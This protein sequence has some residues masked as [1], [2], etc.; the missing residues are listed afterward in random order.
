MEP[1]VAESQ[2]NHD[3]KVIDVKVTQA[4]PRSEFSIDLLGQIEDRYIQ[5]NAPFITIGSKTP[6]TYRIVGLG[7][8]E[9]TLILEKTV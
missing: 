3:G 9:R 7:E 8:G 2:Y 4:P 6:V 5:I 1:I